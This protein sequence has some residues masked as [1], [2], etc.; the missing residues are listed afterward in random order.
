MCDSQRGDHGDACPADAPCAITLDVEVTCTGH[1]FAAGGVRAVPAADATY[2]VTSSNA[3]TRLFELDDDGAT[4]RDFDVQ[5]NSV[6]VA[7]SP[8]GKAYAAVDETEGSLEGYPGGVVFL[9][10]AGSAAE[11]QRVFDR[12]D[13]YVPVIDVAMDSRG[14][15]HIWIVTDAPESVAHATRT[16]G[17]AWD[18][19]PATR[20][21]GSDWTR[22]A[23]APDDAPLAFGMVQAR[24]DSWQ[25][26]VL[27]GTA[28][29]SLGAPV[30]GSSPLRYEPVPPPQPAG[31]AAIPRVTAI[32]QH[33]DG[34]RLASGDEGDGFDEI[35]IPST[36]T[37]TYSC[38][39]GFG[40]PASPGCPTDCHE[41]TSGLE[42]S[43][44]SA[45]RTSDGDVW[46]AFVIS[47]IDW[48]IAY[49]VQH[50]DLPTCVGNIAADASRGELRLVRVPAAGGAPEVAVTLPLPAIAGESHFSDV[51]QRHPLVEVS[52]FGTELTVAL[53]TQASRVGPF[54]ARVLRVDTSLLGPA[55][56]GD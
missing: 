31:Q 17:G 9:P 29:R 46:I 28:E 52:A 32:V 7:L 6:N 33:P 41:V 34:L 5:S 24:F 53:R 39:R 36:A 49:E 42:W 55:A 10:L 25:L 4:Q 40:D 56:P 1:D 44:F 20:P 27:D 51:Y 48:T 15:P 21:S 30:S 54:T 18:V 12:D 16:S 3:P 26:E 47:H 23:L 13:K 8:D 11:K 22:F 45:A 2:L 38:Q 50:A 14:E 35:A 43:A 37:P 19:A